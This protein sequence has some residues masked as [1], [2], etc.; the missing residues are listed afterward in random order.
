MG[1]WVVP[2]K[3]IVITRPLSDREFRKLREWI[4]NKDSVDIGTDSKQRVWITNE[5]KI[6]EH[7]ERKRSKNCN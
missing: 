1:K 7:E 6:R 3:Y 5:T 4:D 2:R